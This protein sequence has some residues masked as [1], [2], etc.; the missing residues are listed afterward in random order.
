VTGSVTEADGVTPVE[1]DLVFESIAGASTTQ[2]IYTSGPPL[3]LNIGNF[4]YTG[5]TTASLDA[6]GGPSSYSVKLP[7]GQYQL[8][9]R[10]LDT[11]HA[12]TVQTAILLAPSTTPLTQNVVVSLPSAVTGVAALADGRPLAGAVVEVLPTQCSQG[13]STACMPRSS[14]T[15]TAADGTYALS[16]DP[17]GYVLRIEPADGTRFPWVTQSLLVGPT[18]VAVPPVTVPA[19][20]Y[21]GLTLHD[22]YDNPIV[23]SIVRVFQVPGAGAA[24][25]IGRAITD[26]TGQYDMYLAPSSQ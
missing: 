25:E 13:T 15:T 17:G 4:E 10:P 9:I 5:Q 18:F 19:P 22:P 3:T 11:S 6:V 12:V 14:Q 24:V 26:A 20:V 16:L 23:S 2:G 8:T 21:A 7:P 1:A